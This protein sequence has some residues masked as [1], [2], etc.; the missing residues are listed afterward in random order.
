MSKEK[1][2]VGD[3]VQSEDGCL[4]HI[5]ED[6]GEGLYNIA[7]MADENDFWTSEEFEYDSDFYKYIGKAKA[8][9]K[10]LFN[11]AED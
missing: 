6:L 4:I 8:K 7:V 10:D 9:M 2:E 1:L 5:Y 3:L 11:V